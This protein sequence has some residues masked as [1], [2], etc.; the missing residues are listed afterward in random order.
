MLL[1]SITGVFAVLF[2]AVAAHPAAPPTS[3]KAFKTSS[4]DAMEA[5]TL[6]SAQALYE[7]AYHDAL[8][9]LL[10]NASSSP[11]PPVVSTVPARRLKPKF[12]VELIDEIT[13][14]V[15]RQLLPPM[16]HFLVPPN[17]DIR[18]LPGEN[19]DRSSVPDPSPPPEVTILPIPRPDGI[20]PGG[21]ASIVAK[22]TEPKDIRANI[23]DHAKK[24]GFSETDMVVL[25]RTIDDAQEIVYAAQ[26]RATNMIHER[27]RVHAYNGKRGWCVCKLFRRKGCSDRDW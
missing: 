16:I 21:E 8:F 14:K 5:S 15:V 18:V 9:E 24:A 11:T 20:P 4:M 22:H 19:L 3:A 7:R 12:K 10:N 23:L 13:F 1:T 26:I 6:P 25:E 2:A 17:I 27:H